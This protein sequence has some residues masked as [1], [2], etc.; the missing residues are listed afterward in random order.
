MTPDSAFQ[1]QIF[2]FFSETQFWPEEEMAAYQN[3]Q[4]SQ[5]VRF[6]YEKSPFYRDR[7]AGL[8]GPNG[9]I[10]LKKWHEVP[11]LTREDLL[12]HRE[13]M[14]VAE[15]PPGH[16]P[17]ADH[18]GTGTTGK[19]VTTTHNHLT[20]LASQAALFRALNW[21]GVDLGSSML[22]FMGEKPLGEADPKGDVLGMWGPRWFADQDRGLM[23]EASV[24]FRPEI[25]CQ[26]ILERNVKVISGRPQAM[27]ALALAAE[28]EKLKINLNMVLGIGTSVTEE[29]RE[30]CR[31]VFG[32]K[33]ISFYQSKEV[34]DIAHQCSESEQFHVS[35][36]LVLLEVLDDEGNPTPIGETGRCVVTSFYNTAQPIIRYDLG[37][38]IRMGSRCSCGR[39]LP[40]IDKIV[41]RTSQLFRFPN[42]RKISPVLG[43]SSRASIRALAG[44]SAY[45]IAQTQ[46][47][48]LELRYIPNGSRELPDAEGLQNIFRECFDNSVN[49]AWKKIDKL[50]L[51]AGGKFLEYVCELPPSN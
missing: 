9:E 30:D 51:T 6:A 37:D 41:G 16:G 33:I 18:H 46:P 12:N 8:I 13:K 10:N 45:Q 15:L 1:K 7:L 3:S 50:P 36:E 31:R 17:T 38:R 24:D 29:M 27:Q 23:I 26:M 14:V 39:T 4:L 34:Y 42:G 21:H 32:A 47:A 19:P 11:I 2:D 20:G 28:R 49:F 43:P 44:A 48:I 40:I 22:R 25:V 5:L 35:S